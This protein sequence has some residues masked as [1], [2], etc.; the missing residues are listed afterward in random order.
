[1]G[2][3][4]HA[5]TVGVEEEFLIIDPETG[6]LRASAEEVVPEAEQEVGD[7]VDPEFKLSQVETA[8]PACGSLDELRGELVRLRRGVLEAADRA[9]SQVG[10]AG[11]HPYPEEGGSEVTPKKS[12]RGLEQ[13]YQRLARQKIICGCH[14]HVGLEDREMAVQV[15]N[16][17]R[18]YLS[19]VL[20][21][22]ANSPFWCSEDSGY[23][24]FRT[25]LWRQ[26]PTAGTPHQFASREE[27]ESFVDVLLKTGAIDDPARIF[28]DVRPSARFDTL[29]YRV[30]DVCLSVDET[31]MVAALFRALTRTCH[32]EVERDVPP[33]PA[34]PE[35][36][37][38]ATW[39]A[40]RY[41][42]EGQLID[43]TER[44]QAP[45]AEVV[46]GL[47]RYLRADLEEAGEW[48]EV[49]SLVDRVLQDGT[50][51]ARQR[52]AFE[53]SQRLEDVVRLVVEETKAGVV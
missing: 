47:L 34:R 9:G 23:A 17:V 40:A 36:L 30:T 48:E 46:E 37:R 31:V 43:V 14:V 22:A 21:L 53:R 33:A 12:Y 41:G 5:F 10:A 49:R 11:T 29:E 39:R 44:T 3:G 26:W 35:L 1:M 42:M 15:M 16:R 28:W 25:E 24:S 2:A 13:E 50:G 6:R 8:T 4:D 20:A 52:R 7:Q 27:Y 45:A 18:P 19:V 51:A 38:A 32:D